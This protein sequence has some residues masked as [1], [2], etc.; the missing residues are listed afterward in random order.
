MSGQFAQ[1]RTIQ[2][3]G[4]TLVEVLTVIT[5]IGILAALLIPAISGFVT[6]GKE[7][8][9]KM[10]IEGLSQAVEQYYNKYGDYPPDFSDWSVVQRHY[11]RVFPQIATE[12]MTLLA[13]LCM[14]ADNVTFDPTAINRA[15]ALVFTLGGYSSDKRR[16]F[17]GQGG[18]L[19]VLNSA[20]PLVRGNVHYNSDRD[21]RMFDFDINRLTLTNTAGVT[22]SIDDGAGI[23]DPLPVLVPPGKTQPIIYFDSR[24]Y[25]FVPLPG[26]GS[27]ANGFW[28]DGAHG[29]VRPYKT[30]VDPEFP[31]PLGSST[32]YGTLPLALGAYKFKNPDTFQIISAGLD[33][34]YGTLVAD[35]QASTPG[36]LTGLPI[37]FVAEWGIA[38]YPNTMAENPVQTHFGTVNGFQD[39]DF[40][41]EI[42]ENGQLDNITNFSSGRLDNDLVE[43]A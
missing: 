18:P 42:N 20:Q 34:V 16:P 35:T 5:I 10:E 8:A 6:K 39:G 40:S 36:D 38:M 32:P 23:P 13:S 27:V 2:R 25:G 9:L 19:E 37:Y 11:R 15:E 22:M 14:Q 1:R 26:G 33:D 3:S 12:E 4:F 24:T 28:V 31:K 43:G 17:S 29:G 7:T 21:N 30:A 41:A